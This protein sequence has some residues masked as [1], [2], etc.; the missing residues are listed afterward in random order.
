MA[1]TITLESGI[2]RV[3]V[4]TFDDEGCEFSPRCA[5]CPLH[6][7]AEVIGWEIARWLMT[8][9]Q[10]EI[11]LAREPALSDAEVVARLDVPAGRGRQGPEAALR[12]A[13]AYT[14]EFAETGAIACPI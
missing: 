10:A 1:V 13:L 5:T 4:A 11:L 14:A 2:G 9:M 6:E 12:H 3:G 8:G 7:C